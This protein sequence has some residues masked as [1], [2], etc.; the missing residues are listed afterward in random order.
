[1]HGVWSVLGLAPVLPPIEEWAGFAALPIVLLM[2]DF[3]KYWEH[4]F[5]HRF[6]WRVHRVHHSPTQLHAMANYGH[7]L[8]AV[9][10]SLLVY[11]PLSFVNF[12]S[13][14]VPIGVAL[15]LGVANAISHS[16]VDFHF[17]PLRRVLIDNRFHRIHH[18]LEARHFDK[19]FGVIFSFWDTLFG[20]AY[21]PKVDEWPEVGV[22]GVPE[23]R[24][25]RAFLM[26]PFREPSANASL[27]AEEFGRMHIRS[28]SP[29]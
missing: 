6:F 26:Q 28:M 14:V 10:L 4:R 2:T 7:P 16:P 29:N 22:S 25:F 15:T 23:A 3:L 12:D 19:N 9:P 20:T 27:S 17:G 5:E 1:M 11:L 24:T 13:M 8:Y 18:S 21:F